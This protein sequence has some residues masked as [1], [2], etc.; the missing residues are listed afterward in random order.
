MFL[1]TLDPGTTVTFVAEL[2]SSNL[3]Q[4]YLW[5]ADAYKG[6]LTA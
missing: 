4:L 5:E 3:P 1:I 2:R 6:A